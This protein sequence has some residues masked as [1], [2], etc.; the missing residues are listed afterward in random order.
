MI[1]YHGTTK[2]KA[3]N[4]VKEGF[5]L[6]LQGENGNHFG[7]GVYLATTKKRAKCYGNHVVSVEIDETAMT[8]VTNWYN[9]YMA[10]CKQIHEEFGVQDE[11][12]N[13]MAGESMKTMYTEQGYTGIIMDSLMGTAKE[14][15]VYDLSII[16][17][18]WK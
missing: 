4:I 10:K 15:V 14:L 17:E 3:E 18:I 2:E 6:K 7:N 8:E 5:N 1:A 13:E 16:Q 11:K 12:V 9:S